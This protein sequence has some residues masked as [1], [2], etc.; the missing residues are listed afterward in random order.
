MI[1][2]RDMLMLGVLGVGGVGLLGRLLLS[3]KPQPLCEDQLEC[4]ERQS[5]QSLPKSDDP[6]WPILRKCR[7]SLD[8]KSGTYQLVP[9]PEV[10]ALAGKPVQVKGFVV[11]LDGS[12]QTKDFLIGVNTPVCF[13]HPPGDPNELME[14]NA[15]SPIGWTDR[16]TTVTGTFTLIQNNQAGVFFRLVDARSA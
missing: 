8:Q 11:P 9:T 3:A 4:Q 15:T 1:R 2:R 14:V 10:L 12:D 5:Q 6:I 16:P 7:V 13:Y